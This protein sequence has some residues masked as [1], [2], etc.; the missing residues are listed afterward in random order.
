MFRRRIEVVAKLFYLNPGDIYREGNLRSIIFPRQIATY[1]LHQI[2]GWSISSIALHFDQ[3][4]TTVRR[5][6][7]KLV[8]EMEQKPITRHLVDKAR[9]Q[10]FQD[11]DIQ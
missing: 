4:T 9:A 8:A 7:Q 3:A 10:C 6:C 2:G 5:G 11:G 1:L